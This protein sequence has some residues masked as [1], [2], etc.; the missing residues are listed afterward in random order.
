MQDRERLR[1]APSSDITRFHFNQLLEQ[2]HDPARVRSTHPPT[3]LARALGVWDTVGAARLHGWRARTEGARAP[4]GRVDAAAR[5]RLLHAALFATSVGGASPAGLASANIG[6]RA[7][8]RADVAARDLRRR[9]R[10]EHLVVGD[11][12]KGFGKEDESQMPNP[13]HQKRDIADIGLMRDAAPK[14]NA[15]HTAIAVDEPRPVED[16]RQEHCQEEARTLPGATAAG[17][18]QTAS[19]GAGR[20]APSRPSRRG[21]STSAPA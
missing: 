3:S 9:R 17:R 5:R 12:D 21:T 19:S 1:R 4:A 16:H 14:V 7:V 11:D 18:R 13:N 10:R 2:S 20:R 15:S 8:T 6:A